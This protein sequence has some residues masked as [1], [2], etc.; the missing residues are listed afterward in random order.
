LRGAG[1]KTKFVR[2]K[3]AGHGYRPVP[4]AATVEPSLEEI[5]RLQM[6]WFKE[7]LDR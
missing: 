3:N 5:K 6:Q 1:L 4:E 2:V 7:V